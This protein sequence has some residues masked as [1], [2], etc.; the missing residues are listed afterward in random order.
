[1]ESTN[2]VNISALPQD[3]AVENLLRHMKDEEEPEKPSLLTKSELKAIAKDHGY[4]VLKT[5]GRGSF[6]KIYLARCVKSKA[7]VAIKV[8]QNFAEFNY[9]M[10]KVI[11]EVA[12]LASLTSIQ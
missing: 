1:M 9:T 12:I 7:S 10:L 8:L 3:E 11:R 6:G 4:E 5:I 2:D